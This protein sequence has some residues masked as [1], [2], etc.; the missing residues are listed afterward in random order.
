MSVSFISFFSSVLDIL[1]STRCFC[2]V[3]YLYLDLSSNL[4]LITCFLKCSSEACCFICIFLITESLYVV[5][6]LSVRR[7]TSILFFF[8]RDICFRSSLVV[9]YVN[10]KST[11]DNSLI[12]GL[13]VVVILIVLV[14]G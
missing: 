14:D 8:L 1:F 13:L 4:Y 7:D 6:D 9:I 2:L 10:V 3:S 5:T 12:Y 11:K